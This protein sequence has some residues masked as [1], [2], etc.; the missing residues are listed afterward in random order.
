MLA[1]LLAHA[2]EKGVPSWGHGGPHDAGGRAPKRG[3]RRDAN[4]EDED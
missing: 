2:A 4:S 3:R 1:A